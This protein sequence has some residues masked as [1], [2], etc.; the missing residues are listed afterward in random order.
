MSASTPE[1]GEVWFAALDPVIAGEQGGSRPVLV[2]SPEAFNRWPVALVVVVP[3]TTRDRGFDHHIPI[4][5]GGIDRASFAMPEYVRAVSQ[6][7]LSRRLGRV[8][9]STR[10]DVDAWLRRI[11]GL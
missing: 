6:R 4:A 7:R 9:A 10:D 8:Q 11:T 3:I 1:R 2:V 5:E